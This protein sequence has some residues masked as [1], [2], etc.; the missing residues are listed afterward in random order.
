M[1]CD[2]K[3]NEYRGSD[4][5]TLLDAHGE[6]IEEIYETMNILLEAM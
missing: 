2:W 6:G 5:I 4:V 1:C 3:P